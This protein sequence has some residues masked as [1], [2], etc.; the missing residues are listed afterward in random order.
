MLHYKTPRQRN[1]DTN[2]TQYLAPGI[3]SP[4]QVQSFVHSRR[5]LSQRVCHLRKPAGY[6]AGISLAI[7][8]VAVYP[9]VHLVPEVKNACPLSQRPIATRNAFILEVIVDYSAFSYVLR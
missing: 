5:I 1:C 7:A 6:H 8:I 2:A 3:L 9:A 4:E